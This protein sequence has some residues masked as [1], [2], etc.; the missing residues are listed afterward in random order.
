MALS[1]EDLDRLLDESENHSL[2]KVTAAE[3]KASP[4]LEQEKIHLLE[5]IKS[6]QNR[7]RVADRELED[8]KRRPLTAEQQKEIDR[9]LE[10]LQM[11]L[12][13]G[14]SRVRERETSG[15]VIN[16]EERQIEQM[17]EAVDYQ[18]GKLQGHMWESNQYITD[19]YMN[20]Q[21][22]LGNLQGMSED[23]EKHIRK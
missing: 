18:A 20:R 1:N 14:E 7:L 22:A 21:N 9:K 13:Y 15:K 12:M 4:E 17:K 19:E 8:T 23:L 5:K 11:A 6:V 2:E 16:P 10:V 3:K